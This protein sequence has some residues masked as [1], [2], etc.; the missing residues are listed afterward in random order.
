M[1]SELQAMKVKGVVCTES[2]GGYD[3]VETNETRFSAS[4]I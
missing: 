4:P 3:A 2:R 1:T